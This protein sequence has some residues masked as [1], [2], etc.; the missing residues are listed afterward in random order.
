MK[1]PGLAVFLAL[2]IIPVTGDLFAKEIIS[3]P[4]RDFP[5]LYIVTG[6]DRGRGI[7]DEAVSAVQERL[8]E[9]DH[10]DLEET[11]DQRVFFELKSGNK[12]CSGGMIWT[13]NRASEVYYSIPYNTV[14]PLRIYFLKGKLPLFK[15]QIR[16][17]GISLRE[18][19][20]NRKLN[21]EIEAGRSYGD[22]LDEVIRENEQNGMV[23]RRFASNTEGVI[24]MMLHG[25]N[26]DLII[27]YPWVM[28]YYLKDRPELDSFLSV[29]IL[30]SGRFQEER[31]IAPRTEWG[32]SFIRRIDEIIR[33]K[34]VTDRCRKAVSRW[35]DEESR[36]QFESE[37]NE[38]VKR[39]DSGS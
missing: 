21:L 1:N 12:L 2:I 5:P 32:K 28:N 30:E 29:R 25:R 7:T 36:I 39:R 15:D 14:P 20:R 16:N 23:V 8:I 31:F 34:S 18:I 26:I 24:Q 11:N 3:W 17:G 19:L 38:M 37:F 35:L 22:E 9:Y 6:E 27:E 13:K 4:R 10:A 33:E